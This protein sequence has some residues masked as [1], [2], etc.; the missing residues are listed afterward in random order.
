[1]PAWPV[2]QSTPSPSNAAV[3]RFAPGRSAGSGKTATSCV[4]GSTRT[5]AFSPPS[6]IQGAPSGPTMTPCG[7]EPSPSAIVVT[8]P[9]AGSSWPSVPSRCA[10]VPDAPVGG[11]RDVMRMRARRH[12]VLDDLERRRRGCGSWLLAVRVGSERGHRDHECH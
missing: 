3:L 5:I 11:R 12:R 7:A 1:M 9:V 2:N 4:A 10:G 8:S 6:V